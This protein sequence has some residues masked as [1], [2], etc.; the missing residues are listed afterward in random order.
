MNKSL[1]SRDRVPPLPFDPEI[2]DPRSVKRNQERAKRYLE[3]GE[4][5]WPRGMDWVR[6]NDWV[7]A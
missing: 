1:D 5:T 3:T 7:G 6:P 4:C 2:I